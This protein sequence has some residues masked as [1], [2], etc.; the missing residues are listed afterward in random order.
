MA[1]EPE[2]RV[3][4]P[5]EWYIQ[6]GVILFGMSRIDE[7]EDAPAV[8]DAIRAVADGDQ[9]QRILLLIA[10]STNWKAVLKG[11]PGTAADAPII[12]EPTSD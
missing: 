1:N 12:L 10:A 9:L 3:R 7:D 2:Q 5:V 4:Q 8:F 6:T 11:L